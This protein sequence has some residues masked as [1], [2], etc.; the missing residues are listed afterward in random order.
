MAVSKHQNERPAITDLIDAVNMAEPIMAQN[1]QNIATL[2][3]GLA[4]ESRAREVGDSAIQSQIGEG[5]SPILTIAQS[6]AA[7]NLALKSIGDE[8]GT[9]IFSPDFTITQAFRQA[10]L[11]VESVI[12]WQ[13]RFRLG[14]TQSVTVEAGSSTSDTLEFG[15]QFSDDAEVAVFLACVDGSEILTE[16]SC[17]LVSA[18]YS[19]FSFAVYNE[20]Q[21]DVTI[22]V[23]FLAVKVN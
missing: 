6:L 5:F 19:G 16:L 23:G 4:D 17:K 1:V 13:E 15:N 12:E 18:T 8:I 22:K 2:T 9:G 20:T 3:E 14:L 21:A 11:A 10:A 7:T